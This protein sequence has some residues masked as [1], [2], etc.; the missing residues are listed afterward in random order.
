MSMARSM[1]LVSRNFR[2]AL[3]ERQNS[4]IWSK[5]GRFCF[6]SSSAWGLNI[7]IGW[8]WMWQSVIKG[9]SVGRILAEFY[10]VYRDGR[11][12]EPELQCGTRLKRGTVNCL[13]ELLVRLKRRLECEGELCGAV[14]L[15]VSQTLGRLIH[16]GK[17]TSRNPPE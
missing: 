2:K 1:P 11:N 9:I 10:Q 12:Q 15:Q 16:A 3:G 8:M 13:L 5:L 6:I 4:T 14:L 17:M 7:S